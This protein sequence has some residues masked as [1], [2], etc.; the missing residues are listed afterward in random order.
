MKKSIMVFLVLLL[1]FSIF[2][3]FAIS[4][5]IIT[6][7]LWRSSKSRVSANTLHLI[8]SIKNEDVTW[9][10]NYL[11]LIPKLTGATLALEDSHE[12]INP[13]LIDALVDENKFVAV[14]VLL[15]FRTSNT[16][17]LTASEWNGLAV[18][19]SPNGKVSFDGNN[20][21]ELQKRWKERLHE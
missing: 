21:R 13:L 6:F 3:I 18:Q 7:D 8:A 10:L 11:G 4:K 15:T 20:L 16:D 2:G 1:L 14:H 5:G 17:R 9:D 19:V 12:D